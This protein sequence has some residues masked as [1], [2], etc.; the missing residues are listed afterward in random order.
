MQWQ[1]SFATAHEALIGS[2][3][4]QHLQCRAWALYIF[5]YHLA[6]LNIITEYHIDTVF[7]TLV[8]QNYIGWRDV[9]LGEKV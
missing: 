2:L 8:E 1:L 7:L 6:G 4:R 3:Q 5:R 9:S